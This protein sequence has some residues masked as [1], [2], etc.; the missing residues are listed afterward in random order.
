MEDARL[1]AIAARA[2][3]GFAKA[4]LPILLV[5]TLLTVGLLASLVMNPP[6]FN[7]DLDRFAPEGEAIEAHDRIHE[8]FPNE[9]RPMFVHVVRDDGG[10]VLDLDHLKAM[11]ADESALRQHPSAAHIVTWATAPTVLDVALEERAEGEDLA[12]ISDW[13]TLLDLVLDEGTTC[14]LN[15]DDALLASATFAASAMLHQDLDLDPVC[16]WLSD[17]SGTPVPTAS[18]TLWVLDV[19]PSLSSAEREA[20]QDELRQALIDLSLIHI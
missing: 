14:S 11:H 6:E 5:A 17:G 3:P 13:S 12:N 9:R 16:A 1:E 18:S 4:S 2:A 20:A 8:H 7:T 15:D 19:D 10:N